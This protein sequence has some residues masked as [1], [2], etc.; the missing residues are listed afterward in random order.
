M[1]YFPSAPSA[2][3]EVDELPLMGAIAPVPQNATIPLATPSQEQ[4][5]GD[6]WMADDF[7]G[8]G[9]S[10]A[11]RR[12]NAR[13]VEGNAAKWAARLDER[14]NNA[15]SEAIGRGMWIVQ[16]VNLD[17][18]KNTHP[19]IKPR[20][21]RVNQDGKSIKYE[22]LPKQKATPVLPFVPT[23]F[24]QRIFRSYGA[25]PFEGETFWQTVQRCNL[26][27]VITEGVK[28]ALCLIER[29]YPAISL[30]GVDCIRKEKRGE[31]HDAIAQFATPERQIY[32][33]F[34]QDEKPKT[35]VNVARATS[36]IASALNDKGCL[37]SILKWGSGLGKGVDD[38]VVGQGDHGQAWLDG[39]IASA[40]SREQ[41]EAVNPAT[42]GDRKILAQVAA[43]DAERDRCDAAEE[44][45][46]TQQ[47][48]LREQ[49][50]RQRYRAET[51]K[52]QAQ[53][54]GLDLDAEVLTTEYLER[55]HFENALTPGGGV[56]LI[57]AHMGKRKTSVGLKTIVE[58]HRE[59]HPESMRILAAP[60][61]LL[62]LQSAKN[63]GLTSH[64]ELE[65]AESGG[66]KV[67][68]DLSLCL[69]SIRRLG[70]PDEIPG[71]SI[72]MFDEPSQTNAQI[73]E[74]KT[75]GDQ[76]VFVMSRWRQVIRSVINKNGWIVL[77][78][79][80]LT[81]LELETI[82]GAL[83]EGDRIPPVRL[84][85]HR[86]P[87]GHGR[88]MRVL[89]RRSDLE[90]EIEDRLLAGENLMIPVDSA[91]YARNLE[92]KI[93]K[94]GIASVVVVDGSNSFE[95]WVKDLG[96][97]PN[98]W[99]KRTKPRVF[100]FTP[101]LNSGIS[102]DDRDGHFDAVVGSITHLEPR[103]AKQL[104][105]RLRT[106][107][108]R[109]LHIKEFGATDDDLFS[110]SRP[111]L[112]LRDV[113][114][115]VSGVMGL[116][117]FEEYS[118]ASLNSELLSGEEIIDRLQSM[119]AHKDDPSTDY[120]YLSSLWAKYKARETYGKLDL[121][122][123]LIALCEERGYV[124]SVELSKKDKQRDAERREIDAELDSEKSARLAEYDVSGMTIAEARHILGTLGSTEEQ[125]EQAYKRTLVERFPGCPMDDADFLLKA[126]V[127][128]RGRFSKATELL[129]LSQ[130]PEFAKALDRWNWGHH[131]TRGMQ[132]GEMIWLPKLSNRSAQAKLMSECPLEPF[133]SGKIATWNKD[134][135][136]AIAVKDWAV[137]RSRQFRRHLRLSF[138][139]DMSPVKIVNKLLRKLGFEIEETGTK[140]GKHGR[141]QVSQYRIANLDDIDRELI[142]NSLS[143]RLA[144]KAWD[145]GDCQDL[146]ALEQIGEMIS[147]KEAAGAI[148]DEGAW[149]SEETLTDVREMWE[150][151]KLEPAA[152]QW[153][154]R[155][156]PPKTL[157]LALSPVEV[158]AA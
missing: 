132:Q 4:Q 9:V 30:R 102:F 116:A 86:S 92:R 15:K 70:N 93:K 17:G 52:I 115:N 108:D 131:C 3:N 90:R 22:T 103:T 16:G 53:L 47:R 121:R 5:S 95:K 40:L 85:K 29:G 27:V 57:D 113:H 81:N 146:I 76:H 89:K 135:P 21:P 156:I 94:L 26:P 141:G 42:E 79:D 13:Y 130:N 143:E 66:D 24:A 100:I 98:G 12:A 137:L 150:A 34:D 87:K 117:K 45:E 91:K 149:Q 55:S 64:I 119:N 32:I 154:L 88:K 96:A 59:R 23:E 62:A 6:Q 152:K 106:D 72:L 126:F 144:M 147:L 155:N 7:T 58:Q 78:E 104:A 157:R 153:V 124:V 69:P 118:R 41:W 56:I 68:L 83:V 11:L 14:A 107:V 35:I 109:V 28:K 54:N 33:C 142:L 43:E 84:I 97:D 125:R 10:E 77:A 46:R 20:H 73:L 114:R 37:V 123:N 49:E 111:D 139:A 134:T 105:E 101:S 138:T 82:M 36:T 140:G 39:V 51:E 44:R 129:W 122:S 110:G 80:G 50:R 38:A 127:G 151:A 74:G 99:L 18:S 25:T 148:V 120:G 67:P 2:L 145:K 112:I 8:S 61:R 60:T 19:V 71:N 31:L 136:E 48:D 65:G 75:C 128:D 1:N 133:I 63:L 158:A